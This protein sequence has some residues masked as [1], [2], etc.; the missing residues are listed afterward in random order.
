MSTIVKFTVLAAIVGTISAC[1]GRRN[2]DVVVVDPVTPPVS[3][4]DVGGKF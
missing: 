3:N 4:Q 2:D 1:G